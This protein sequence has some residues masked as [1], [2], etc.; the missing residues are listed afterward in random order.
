M[1]ERLVREAARIMADEGLHDFYLAKRKAAARLGAP[2]TGNLPQNRE[3]QEALAEYQ[4][5]F[6]GDEQAANVRRLREA[7]LEAMEFFARF[8]PRLVGSVL[9]GTADERSEVNLHLFADT[10]DE[11][12][13]FLMESDIP[14]DT[15]ERRYRFGREEYGFVPVY[16]FV[17]GGVRMDLAVF[18][19][20]WV[21][22][23][24]RSRVDG[25][26]VR[27]A[28]PEEVRQ[29][30]SAELSNRTPEVP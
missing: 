3:I 18:A 27:R 23:P 15:E 24:P 16:R 6:G 26:P 1:R 7:A 29:L 21:S 10:P 22:H 5:L 20:R 13:V 8:R 11:V 19:T 4:R 17:A 14:Y 2:S 30:I 12:A 28:G 25:Q 9:D